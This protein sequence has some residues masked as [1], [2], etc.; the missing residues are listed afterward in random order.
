M[1]AHEERYSDCVTTP[2]VVR[3]R[4]QPGGRIVSYDP[5]HLDNLL[6]WAV[7]Q[8]ATNGEGVPNA[9]DAYSIPLPLSKLWTS[10][11][12]LPLWSA[13]VMLAADQSSEDVAY[14]HKRAISGQ[15]SA[16]SSKRFGIS[17]TAGRH[18]ER[19]LPTPTTVCDTWIAYADGW[20]EE[21][22]RLLGQVGYVGKHRHTGLGEVREWSVEPSSSPRTWERDG[23]L[24]KPMPTN[25]LQAL[26]ATIRPEESEQLVG[27]T[28]P[29]WKPS[30]FAVGFPVGTR[31]TG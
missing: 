5:V 22:S 2:V 13:S 20:P 19:R 14:Y 23:V 16:S 12:G 30:L 10:D 9:D 6:A 29:Q 17:G 25:A 1:R 3:L 27:W 4:L 21:I 18:M 26:G 8:E 28:P 7:V 11:E 31:I 24:V 15:W